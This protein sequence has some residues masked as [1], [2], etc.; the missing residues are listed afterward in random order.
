[1][2]QKGL[3]SSWNDAK[4]F[5]FISPDGGGERV[6]AHISAYEGRGRPSPNRKVV[7]AQ[8]KDKQGRV[9]AARFQYSG[10][11]GVGASVASGV[12]AALVL[13]TGLIGGL[14]ALGL[15]GY[16]PWLVPGAYGTMSV[17]AFLMYAVDKGA[18]EK[19]RRRVPEARLHLI[20]L[21][22]GWPGAL[23][24]QQFFRHKTRKTSFQV[25][26]WFCVILN[27]AALTWVLT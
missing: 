17:V 25:G 23:L 5:G 15:L 4:G 21:L 12:W 1:M 8:G 7:Y 2:D 19:G 11:A 13:A 9:R 14:V 24:G 18:A 10:A 3:L 6:F 26:F 16:V 27:L 20:E 22:C